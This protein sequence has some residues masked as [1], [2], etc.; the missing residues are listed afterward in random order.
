MSY[1]RMINE[2]NDDGGTLNHD[3]LLLDLENVWI[4]LDNIIGISN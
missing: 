3:L 1:T 4:V 2:K